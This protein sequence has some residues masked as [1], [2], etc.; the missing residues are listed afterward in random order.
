MDTFKTPRVHAGPL[1]MHQ[2]SHCSLVFLAWRLFLARRSSPSYLT[3]ARSSSRS[4][5][6]L[7]SRRHAITSE[8]STARRRQRLC[9]KIK[10][11]YC[12]FFSFPPP[13]VSEIFSGLWCFIF[14]DNIRIQMNGGTQVYLATVGAEFNQSQVRPA[15]HNLPSWL[16][17]IIPFQ[18]MLIYLCGSHMRRFGTATART[19]ASNS[20][21]RALWRISI[22]I[23]LSLLLLA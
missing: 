11:L 15:L 22:L 21:V 1:Y 8:G 14:R 6:E 10:D 9:C 16:L 23:F 7:V 19:H 13:F 20:I 4:R 17:L 2:L 3:S 12:F 18:F 5:L